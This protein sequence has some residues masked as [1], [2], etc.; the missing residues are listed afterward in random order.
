[1]TFG[2]LGDFLMLVFWS[3]EKK[4]DTDHRQPGHRDTVARL[5]SGRNNVKVAHIIDAIYNHRSVQPS[6]RSPRVNERDSAF[7]LTIHPTSINFARPSMKAWAAQLCAVQAHR[8]IKT[9]TRNDPDHPEYAPAVLSLHD[10][11]W[12]DVMNYSP[13]RTVATFRACTVFLYNFFEHVSVPHKDGKPVQCVRRPREMCIIASLTPIINGHN[14]RVNGYFSMA[15]GIHLFSGQAHTDLPFTTQLFGVPPG[16][17]NLKDHLT[18]VIANER[19]SMRV[20]SLWKDIDWVHFNDSMELLC[21]R[22]LAEEISVLS[23]HVKTV[24]ERFRTAP[25]AIHRI[26]D[27]HRT[28]IQPL[29]CNS[30]N[31]LSTQGMKRAIDDFNGQIGYPEEAAEMLIEWVGGDG[32]SHESTERVKR[33]LAPTALS[34]RDTHQNKISTPEAWHVKSTAIQTISETHFGPTNGS[35]PSLLSKIFHLVGL[36]RPANLKKVDFYPMVHGFKLT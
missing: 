30:E 15:F 8:D 28:S 34:N 25:M 12:S 11:T 31:E 32:G 6:W 23:S 24:S 36:K 3:R 20:E 5:L 21:I 33:V 29:G 4:T 16:A 14:I 35:D 22:T 1:S 17:W 13:E 27:D 18:R 7:S 19:L 9:L 2:S 10:I 26:P